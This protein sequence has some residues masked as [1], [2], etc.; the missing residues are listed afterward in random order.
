MTLQQEQ[1][2][3][4][5]DIDPALQVKVLFQVVQTREI[6]VGPIYGGIFM[7]KYDREER[8]SHHVKAIIESP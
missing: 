6:N 4:K 8:D 5:R 7:I 3:S 2:Q 1:Q